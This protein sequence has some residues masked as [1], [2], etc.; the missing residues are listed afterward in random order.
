MNWDFWIIGNWSMHWFSN[1]FCTLRCFC[2]SREWLLLPSK[3]HWSCQILQSSPSY[4][5][6]YDG[7]TQGY[8]RLL[9]C[10]CSSLDFF[11]FFC[12]FCPSAL[13]SVRPTSAAVF[14]KLNELVAEVRWIWRLLLLVRIST[15]QCVQIESVTQLD[16][17]LMIKYWKEGSCLYILY[18][19]RWE[20]CFTRWTFAPLIKEL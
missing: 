2:L 7:T 16:K 17:N 19:H 20:S 13:G 18:L 11:F 10:L 6:S 3:F 9:G 12:H 5:E 4:S 1:L 8:S 15:H 14:V